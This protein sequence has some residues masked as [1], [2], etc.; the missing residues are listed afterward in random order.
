[1]I[2]DCHGHYTTEPKD[3]HRFRKEQT[4]AANAK[5]KTAMPSRAALKMPDDEIRE[6]IEGNQLKLQR[7]RGTDLTIFSPR[8][9]GMGHHIG[10]ESVSLEWSQICNDLIAR[11]VSLYPQNFIGVCQLPQSPGVDPK[12]SAAELERCVKMGFV[13]CNLNPDP[14]GG[15]FNS[16]PMTD[17]SWFPLY[18]KMI[19]LDVPCMIHVSGCCNPAMHTTGSYY[20]NA[21]TMVFMQVLLSDLFKNFPKLKFIIPHGGGAVPFHWGRFRGIALNNGKPELAEIMGNNIFFDTCVYH[22][23]G[24]DLLTKVVPIDN[25]LFASE[26][27]GAVKGNDPRTGFGFDD[28]KRYVDKAPISDADRKKIFEGNARSVYQRLKTKGRRRRPRRRHKAHRH[29]RR[30]RNRSSRDE[31]RKT[32]IVRIGTREME[33]RGLADGF[34]TDLYHRSMTVY[35]PVF[36]GTAALIFVLLNAVFASLF[37]LGD[38][39][40][41]NVAGDLPLPLSLFYFS[42]ETLATV[43]YGDMHPQ[44]NYGHVIAT[45]EIFTGMCFLAVM[46]GLIFARFSR[47]RARFIFA[48]HPVVTIASGPADADDP[49]R[50][51]AQQYDL[52]GDRAAVAVSPGK[53]RRRPSATGV[54]TN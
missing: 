21:D 27:V 44:T 32:H 40:I 9:S 2:I 36:F 16:P 17:K 22:Q 34:W 37:Y 24:I 28:T 39:P 23:P 5:D 25:I 4:A 53:H 18:E 19:E 3:L 51:C 11:V 14:S 26:M 45:V 10:D 52:A 38:Q 54:T 48:E 8:A 49:R 31:Q 12:N 29:W 6:S 43:G 47:P 30:L 13:G 42:I 35:W 33:A 46:T 7:E 20:L 41:A 15:Y 50:Q 1:M